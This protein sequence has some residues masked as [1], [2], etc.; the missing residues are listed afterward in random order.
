V[1]TELVPLADMERMAA[2]IAKSKLFGAKTPDEALAIMLL[3]QAEGMHP[4]AAARDYHIIQG[5]PAMKADAMM[6]RYIASGGRV[7]WHDYT[8]AKVSATF[9][10]PAGGTVKIEWSIDMAR[11]IGLAAKDNWKNYPRQMLRARV[12]SE[13]VR[14]TNPA[15]AVG[16]YTPE[17][18]QD[19]D[20]PKEKNMGEAEVIEGDAVTKP[21]LRRLEAT[22]NAMRFDREEVRHWCK[23]HFGKFHFGQL[24][25]AEY[26]KLDAAIVANTFKSAPAPAMDDV[27]ESASPQAS[28]TGAPLS[29][30][31]PAADADLYVTPDQ[32]LELEALCNEYALSGVLKERAGVEFFSQI[33]RA[34]FED[35]K[36]W[37][38]RQAQRREAKA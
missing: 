37:I 11:K 16:I 2:T 17:E 20:Q 28:T 15:V 14:T 4:A 26:Q 25:K 29:P 5:R 12:I 27:S 24:D 30:A 10:H 21:Q 22:I 23:T 6:A 34:E 3:A 13:G 8:D 9:S 33:L 1:S 31:T 35:W 32:A 19:F 7:E 18:V 38:K 36:A